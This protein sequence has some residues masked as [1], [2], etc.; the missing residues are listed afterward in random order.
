MVIRVEYDVLIANN[1]WSLVPLPSG[2]F[3][4][5][6]KWVFCI[7]ENPN[8]SINK[9]KV[10]LVAKGFHQHL[11]CDYSKTFSS[12]VKLV[13]IRVILILAMSNSWPT[14]QVDVNNAFL[15][16]ILK[17]DNYMVRPPDFESNDKKHVCKL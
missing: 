2:Y 17:E 13:K 10:C 4:V 12:V 3:T 9:Y 5:G 8:Y 11:G 1:T 7:K 15:N 14:K 16:G 6:C